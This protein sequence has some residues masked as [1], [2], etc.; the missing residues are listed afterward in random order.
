MLRPPQGCGR[1]LLYVRDA[2]TPA[3]DRWGTSQPAALLA[4]L[5]A[6]GGF[7]DPRHL[8]FIGALFRHPTSRRAFPLAEIDV[9]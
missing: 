5:L 9:F 1:L 4:Q 3:P 8:E 6:H 7:Y 2:D